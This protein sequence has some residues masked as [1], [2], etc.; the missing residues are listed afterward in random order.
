MIGFIIL[1]FVYFTPPLAV[2]AFSLLPKM[3][4]LEKFREAIK[5]NIF[6]IMG[7]YALVGEFP[8]I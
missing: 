8:N 4:E 3:K 6:I 5:E 7:I 2:A 1:I